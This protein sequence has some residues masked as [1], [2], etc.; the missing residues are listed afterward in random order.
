VT[1]ESHPHNPADFE[2]AKRMVRSE[3]PAVRAMV[4]SSVEARPELLYYLAADQA[5]SVRRAIASNTETPRQADLLLAADKDAAVRAAVAE[6]I[7]K[8]APGLSP[9]RQ[10]QIERMTVSCLETLA[11]DQAAGIRVILAE[12]LKALP[13]APR[14]VINRLARDVE[15]SVCGPVLRHS[16]ILTDDDLFD[17]IASG[18]VAGA[19]SAIASRGTVSASLADA[20]ARADDEAAM[21]ALLANPSAQIR[22]ETLD[23]I[24]DEAPR[25]EPWHGPLVR[26]PKL[27]R[28]AIERLA[29]FVADNLLR[30]LRSR[31]DLDPATIVRLA[32]IVRERVARAAPDAEPKVGGRGVLDFGEPENGEEAVERPMD[33]AVRLSR[34][35]KLTERLLE[36][37]LNEG[38]RALVTSGLSV[39]STIPID[40]VD[41]IIASHAARPVI[42]L[43]WRAGLSMRFA[44]QIQ[45]RLAQVPPKS[46]LNAKGG[47][48]FPLGE[49]ELKWQLEFFGVE[50]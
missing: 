27:P 21:T 49:S 18:P 19:L 44:K 17:I 22:E 41:R 10:S 14:D 28:G 38:D 47:T 42:A 8:I 32:E 24:I 26:R 33:R 40:I 3:D 6:K 7:S 23:R 34:E 15:L 29:A 36:M 30:E 1:N 4:A 31:P 45:L 13:Y 43:V 25:H 11:H 12:A 39:L 48:D 5:P 16:P 37:S 50:C 35:G 2:A 46:V 20:I 9:D